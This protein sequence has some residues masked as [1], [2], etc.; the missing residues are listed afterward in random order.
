MRVQVVLGA[1]RGEGAQA[2]GAQAGL[3]EHVHQ[4]HHAPPVADRGL[5]PAQVPGLGRGVQRSEVDGPGTAAVGDL[6]PCKA[7]SAEHAVQR[8]QLGLQFLPHLIGEPPGVQRL[9]EFRVVLGA[10]RL[11][12]GRQVEVGVAPLLRASN[13]DLLAPQLLPQRLEHPALVHGAQDP[14]ALAVTQVHQLRQLGRDDPVDRHALAR[15]VAPGPAGHLRLIPLDQRER[16]DHGRVRG[17]GRPELQHLDDLDQPGPVVAGVGGLEDPLPVLPVGRA[18][19][20][21][22]AQQRRQRLL[23][24][25]HR[26]VDDVLHPLPGRPQR[27][28]HLE[29]DVLL[30][31]HPLQLRHELVGHLRVRAG[32]DPVHGRDEQVDQGVSDLPLTAVQVGGQQRHHDLGRVGAQVAGRLGCDPGPPA[33]EHPRGHVGEQV[34]RQADCADRAELERLLPD[35]LHA[36]VARLIADRCEHVR[37]GHLR[38]AEQRAIVSGPGV[39]VAGVGRPRDQGAHPGGGLSGH[40][41]GDPRGQRL[42]GLPQRRAD[43]PPDPVTG[44]RLDLLALQVRQQF[45]ADPVGLPLLLAHVRGQPFRRFVRVR[46][47]ALPEPEVPADISP[48][49]CGYQP[50][51]P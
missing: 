27:L 3:G 26:R 18:V 41:A 4:R 21:V 45:L 23:P 2:A 7:L 33:R 43:D 25:G 5:Q 29:Q 36:D 8:R 10:V 13:P 35:G 24:A 1:D 15:R 20:P 50:G 31:R 42:L 48:G 9:A 28:G 39:L 11:E 16:L 22:L 49:T 30:A 37:P 34:A 44:R 12:V 38:S 6:Q 51:E 19:G 17:V 40:P 47:R 32:V 46:D 14:A